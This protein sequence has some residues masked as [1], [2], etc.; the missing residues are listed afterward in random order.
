MQ[1]VLAPL[2][3]LLV[4]SLLVPVLDVPV[5]ATVLVELRPVILPPTNVSPVLL[6]L[7]VL[8]VQEGATLIPIFASN[9]LLTRIVLL[10]V[11]L[12][13]CSRARVLLASSTNTVRISPELPRVTFLIVDVWSAP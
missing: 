13:T 4:W 12:A 2:V 3:V 1:T 5:I 7:T 8:A 10:T 6:V 11:L 9:V